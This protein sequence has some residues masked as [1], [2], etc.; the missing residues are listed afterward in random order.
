MARYPFAAD[1]GTRTTD[2]LDAVCAYN[3]AVD[4]LKRVGFVIETHVEDSGQ[5][6]V[7]FSKLYP[8]PPSGGDA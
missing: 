8:T 1:W 5:I 2:L 3:Q 4:C 6:A 7:S